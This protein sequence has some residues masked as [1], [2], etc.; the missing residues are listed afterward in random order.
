LLLNDIF[1]CMKKYLYL[2]VIY[3][4][5]SLFLSFSEITFKSDN[6]QLKK[7]KKKFQKKEVPSDINLLV[8]RDIN[9]KQ[10]LLCNNVMEVHKIGTAS[11]STYLGTFL[12]YNNIIFCIILSILYFFDLLIKQFFL[13]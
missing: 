8:S 12:K 1:V 4:N 7:R 13:N 9:K 11:S 5:L 10:K 6:F 3:H 2:F